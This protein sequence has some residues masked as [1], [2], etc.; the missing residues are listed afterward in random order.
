MAYKVSYAYTS[1]MGKV[2]RNHEDNFWCAGTFL[3]EQNTGTEGVAEGEADCRHF[4]AAAVMDGMGGECCGETAAYLAAR[5]F[6]EYL[7]EHRPG[8][9]EDKESYVRG[10]YLALNKAVTDYEEENRISSMG[11]TVNAALF[12]RFR[13][14]LSN[15]GDSRIY[16]M[17]DDSLRQVSKDHVL[18]A[19]TLGKAPL[20]QYLG[21]DDP[22]MQPEPSFVSLSPEQGMRI[23]M[24]S[25]GLTDMVP[26]TDIEKMLK[27]EKNN[28]AAV[29]KLLSMALEAGGR[30]NITI[31]LG[32][33]IRSGLF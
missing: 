3:P 22:D 27:E 24:C 17:Q 28:K 19:Y 15:L 31:W 10:L 29:E 1:H 7:K 25:D 26:D 23:L 21:M 9:F 4:T 18:K 13:I 12:F 14:C 33:V 32:E 2:R 5:R 6:G 11:S 8:L 16:V 20:I 30:D